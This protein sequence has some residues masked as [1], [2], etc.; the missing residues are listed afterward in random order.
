MPISILSKIKLIIL[1]SPVRR[2]AGGE[3]QKIPGEGSEY[4]I[5][6][7]CKN[8][9]NYFKKTRRIIL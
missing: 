4:R 5:M 3:V 9:Y 8:Q 7:E 6:I 1:P 2:G